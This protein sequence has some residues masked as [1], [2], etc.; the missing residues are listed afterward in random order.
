[1]KQKWDPK[2]Q[3]ELLKILQ[4]IAIPVEWNRQRHIDWLAEYEKSKQDAGRQ[5]SRVLAGLI[6][7][8][9]L[10]MEVPAKAAGVVAVSPYDSLDDLKHDFEITETL[11]AADQLQA[12]RRLPGNVVSAVVGREFLVPEDPDRDEFDLL[13][14]AVDVVKNADYRLARAAFHA[15]QQQFTNAGKTDLESVTTAVDAMEHHLDELEK[16]V[17][18]ERF[19]NGL[20][21]AFFFTQLATDVA[22]GPGTLVSAGKAAVALGR[23]TASEKMRNPAAPENL[24]PG[25]ALLLD[26][27]RKLDLTTGE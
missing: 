9:K 10:I 6:T 18:K 15:A 11:S 21:R 12:G 13:H 25:G 22:T 20:R 8:E 3:Q 26:A 4:G 2:R 19:W 24:V 17:R 7:A 16:I 27:R 5:L 1:M 23:Y 14:R